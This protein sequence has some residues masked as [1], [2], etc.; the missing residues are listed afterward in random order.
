MD[1]LTPEQA[2]FLNLLD[3]VQALEDATRMLAKD[4]NA[5]RRR[6]MELEI[7]ARARNAKDL[8]QGVVMNHRLTANPDR[9]RTKQ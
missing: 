4:N 3:R 7:A 6:V 2:A 1:N 5:L 9:V 8:S